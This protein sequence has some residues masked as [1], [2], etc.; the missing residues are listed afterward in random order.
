MKKTNKKMMILSF[1][2]IIFVVI[3]HLTGSLTISKLFPYYSFH[4][5]LFIFISGYFYKE[6]YANNLYK[7]DGYFINRFKK[8]VIPYYFW[9][10]I[11]GLFV[12]IL[13]YCGIKSYGNVISFK[14][15]LIDPWFY[16]NQFYFNT[17]AWF[18]LSLFIVNIVYSFIRKIIG[19]KWND[20]IALI[21]FLILAC[22]SIKLSF[23][24]L[25]CILIIN[26]TLF[27]ML[28]Y[29]FGYMYKKIFESK[30]K[31][32]NSFILIIIS[33]I[34]QIILLSID[35][36]IIYETI[37]MVFNCKYI[38]VPIIVGVN[39]I[40]FWLNISNILVKFIGNSKIVNYVSENTFD[41]MMHHLFWMFIFNL[42]I[43]FKNSYIQNF[44][45]IL[46][47]II[48]P[49]LLRLIFNKIKKLKI[50]C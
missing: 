19:K 38:I 43:M 48:I 29:Q 23:Y 24:N 32:I 25:K 44:F 41:I 18:C 35:N 22:I 33:I 27:F 39:G 9:N 26:R 46:F 34:I 15:L 37:Y 3:G 7:K 42:I 1:F 6:E 10:F 28:F 31:N 47:S 17:P 2:G 36:H 20:F 40:W 8:F 13:I 5:V 4:M 30:L 21:I 12:T 16:G 45:C 50:C 49:I 14:T 11:Y